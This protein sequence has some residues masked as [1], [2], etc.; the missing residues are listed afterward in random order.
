[1]ATFNSRQIFGYNRFDRSH[2]NF[3]DANLAQVIPIACDYVIPGT[4]V[5]RSTDTFLRM[6]ALQNPAFADVDL[7][8]SHYFVSMNAI[9]PNFSIKLALFGQNSQNPNLLSADGGALANTFTLSSGVSAGWPASY[10]SAGSLSD[11]LGTSLFLDT[12]SAS[13]S[14]PAS[15]VLCMVPYFAYQM[16]I[17]RFYRNPR[18]SDTERTRKLI[19]RLYPA[20]SSGILDGATASALFTSDASL[21]GA[22]QS[23]FQLSKANWLPDY[24]TTARPTAGGTALNIPGMDFSGETPDDLTALA[25]ALT[26]K[27]TIPA[28]WDAELMQKVSTMLEESGYSY[29]DF[30]R[31]LYD[32]DLSQ[33]QY[34][35]EY[36]VLLGSSRSPL[37]IDAVT[38]T[39]DAGTSSPLGLQAGQGT[40]YNRNNGFTRRFSTYG[41][42]LSVV[43]VRPQCAYF[44]GIEPVAIPRTVGDLPIPALADLSDQ[45]IMLSELDST[46]AFMDASNDGVFG[47]TSRYQEYRT[48]PNRIHG[49]LRTV[50]R[51]WTLTRQ[52]QTGTIS[53]TWVLA[54]PDYAPFFVQNDSEQHFYL[55]CHFNE[56]W[57]LPLPQTTRPYVW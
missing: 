7:E 30:M 1:M 37:N 44:S 28:L 35:N 39:A 26:K 42:L 19:R 31:T 47:Y 46:K 20:L 25:D 6:E 53:N 15:S 51:D 2:R 54:N 27:G 34:E 9:D 14:F 13:T 11:Y 17:D 12:T 10:V 45:P 48:T 8:V 38:Q 3:L 16:V 40:A 23:M 22:W 5:S 18:L 56:D 29:F 32:V 41:V 55:R 43:V 4:S 49:K 52:S 33:S 24:F 57:T 21:L 50:N 36:P